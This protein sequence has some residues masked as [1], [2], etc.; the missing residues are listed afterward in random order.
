VFHDGNLLLKY[1]QE[2]DST[3]YCLDAKTGDTK[4]SVDRGTEKTTWTTPLVVAHGGVTQVVMNG[5]T[6]RSYDLATGK[7]LWSL[8]GGTANPIPSALRVGDSVVCVSGYRGAA[9][10]SIPLKSRGPLGKAAKL[11]W[12][13][14]T[15]TPYVPSPVLADGR[16]YFT[17][18][19]D[20]VLTCLD[21]KT[22]K[23]LLEKERLPQVKNFYAS[24]VAAAGRVYFVDRSGIT[25]VI[26]AGDTLDLL[27]VNRLD[28]AIDASPV[29]VGKQLI[30]R[31]EKFLYCIE[32]K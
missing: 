1:D 8:E 6:I 3:L 30:L 18:A 7:E 12:S 23:V 11:D 22:G 5:A 25:A 26:K 13:Y 16:L 24:P 19:N 17:Q 29:A 2:A 20:A 27:A 28:D 21:A 31:G 14:A 10:F 9:A 15:G 4:W 32:E